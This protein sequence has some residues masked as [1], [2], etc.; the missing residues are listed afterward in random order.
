[1]NKRLTHAPSEGDIIIA[2]LDPVFGD[3]QKKQRPYLVVSVSL[4]NQHFGLCLVSPITT[5]VG[6]NGGSLS[7]SP[8]FV[9]VDIKKGKP[10]VTG[11]VIANQFQ[12]ID[13]RAEEYNCSHKSVA[14]QETLDEVKEALR[15]LA[16]L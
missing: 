8:F 3:V 7:S 10:R 12:T 4:L 1:M 11:K 14:K 6:A 2:D 16:G 15:K 5:G 13:W 9:D